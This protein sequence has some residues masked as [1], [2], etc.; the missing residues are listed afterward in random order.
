MALTIGDA[1]LKL[2]VDTKELDA[3]M[4]KAGK[5][6]ETSMGNM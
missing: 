2:G 6:V 5:S 4:K 1:L 3:G